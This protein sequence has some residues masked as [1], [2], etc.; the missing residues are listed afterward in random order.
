MDIYKYQR[1][2]L[3]VGSAKYK[4]S[5]TLLWDLVKF[6]SRGHYNTGPYL[7][8]LFGNEDSLMA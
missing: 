4:K 5:Y 2:C 7:A 1:I 3:K 6:P 8:L